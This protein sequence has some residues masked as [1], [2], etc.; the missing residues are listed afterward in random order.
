MMLLKHGMSDGGTSCLQFYCR[1]TSSLTV[2][3]NAGHHPKS[4]NG[5][6]DGYGSAIMQDFGPYDSALDP[7]WVLIDG[8][9][10]GVYKNPTSFYRS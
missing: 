4:W 2:R 5:S 7:P 8:L 10:F 9:A 1:A 6:P 3:S